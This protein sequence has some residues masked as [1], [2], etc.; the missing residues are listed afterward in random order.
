MPASAAFLSK[1]KI[2]VA[3]GVVLMAVVGAASYLTISRLLET[4][5]SR[6]RTEDTLVMLERVDSS[7][8]SAESTLR[9]YLLS[10]NADDLEA[11]QAARVELRGIGPA[12]AA[13]TCCRSRRSLT[14]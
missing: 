14:N 7:L 12:R 4:A 9:Q 11:F 1:I 5:Q 2:A 10:G 6:V 3:A 13:P 8:R